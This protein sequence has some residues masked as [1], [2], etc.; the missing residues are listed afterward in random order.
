MA[1]IETVNYVLKL[2]DI[3]HITI[4]FSPIICPTVMASLY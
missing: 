3:A 2:K 1:V 4:P